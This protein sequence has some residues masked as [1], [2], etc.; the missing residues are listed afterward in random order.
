MEFHADD[1]VIVNPLKIRAEVANELEA[2]I[3]LC[4]TGVSRDSATIIAEQSR[5]VVQG[6]SKSIEAM[7]AIKASAVAMKEAL[8]R[9]DF[10]RLATTLREGWVQ[11][12]AM[13]GGISNERIEDVQ[14]AAMDGG[15]Y[16][17]KISG[18]GGGGFMMLL[19]PLERRRSLTAHLEAMGCR[20][21]GCSFTH[22]GATAWRVR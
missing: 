18:A 3:L 10:E 19:V 9:G 8:L 16:A 4:F 17:G 20:L 6:A 5:N 21:E 7:H 15:A 12:R 13:A 11:K 14:R 1:R 2:R 22:E